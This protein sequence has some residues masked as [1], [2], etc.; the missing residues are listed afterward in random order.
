MH[1][2]LLGADDFVYAAFAPWA[3]QSLTLAR[4]AASHR[5]RYRLITAEL[6]VD[7]EPSG[8][9]WYRSPG[10]AAMP[11]TGD[12]VAARVI[13]ATDAIVE[14]VLPRRTLFAR[15]AVGKREEQ[16][17]IA[18]NVDLVFLVSGLDGDYNPRRIERYLILAA[19]SGARPVIVLN[20]RDL[21]AEL[22]ARIEQTREVA[23]GAE[24]VT[25]STVAADGL[26]ELRGHLAPG[27]TVALLG[28]SGV[29][30][31]SIVNGL[32][33]EERLRTNAVR[34]YDSRGR[35]TTTHRELIPLPGG[36]ALID[37][38]GMRELQL[39]AGRESVDRVFDDISEAAADCRFRDCTHNG[40]TGCAVE[41]AVDPERL[42][43]YRKLQN[44]AA[45]HE[46]LSD[47]LA[48]IERKKKWKAI[49]KAARIYKQR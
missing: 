11:V 37:T 23:A 10:A 15:R 7:A 47:P 34:E 17:P 9:L 21:C 25:A 42:A 13:N 33:G 36:G 20:K 32:L 24:V 14:A 27:T 29:G 22:E 5:D 39:W 6:E 12:W 49:H 30:K 4:V 46:T 26:D 35:H 38:P 8:A 19:E 31:S 18:A 40:E 1:L 45:W 41:A 44:E 2:E 48:A 28:S 3:Q 43:S 16:Q